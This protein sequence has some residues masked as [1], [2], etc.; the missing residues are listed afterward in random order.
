M[1]SKDVRDVAGHSDVTNDIDT[2]SLSG[3][4]LHKL[5]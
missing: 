2:N 4:Q 1:S 5:S 3:D